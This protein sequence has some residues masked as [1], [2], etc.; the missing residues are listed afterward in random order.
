MIIHRVIRLTTI[1][2]IIMAFSW[3][4]KVPELKYTPAHFEDFSMEMFKAY[5]AACHGDSAKGDGPATPTLKSPPSDL[6]ILG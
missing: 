2:I 4:Q 6:T 3:P 5:C 1:V